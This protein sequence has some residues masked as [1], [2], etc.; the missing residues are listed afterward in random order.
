MGEGEGEGGD[1]ILGE[2]GPLTP[3]LSLQG[4]GSSWMKTTEVNK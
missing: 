2:F 4:R 1:E 3:T